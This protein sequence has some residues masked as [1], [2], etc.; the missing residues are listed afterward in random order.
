MDVKSSQVFFYVQRNDST[1]SRNSTIIPWNRAELN[2]GNGMNLVTGVFTAPRDGI[3]H[4]SFSGMKDLTKDWMGIYLR[5]NG[6]P[7]SE[8]YVDSTDHFYM[9]T[10][11]IRAIL[12]LRTNDRVDLY[13]DH[14]VLVDWNHHSH[15]TGYLMEEYLHLM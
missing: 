8:A 12:R 14:G 6:R 10:S 11:D 4:F 13:L 9:P 2:I 7:I 5:H 3:Y 1:Y 15:F